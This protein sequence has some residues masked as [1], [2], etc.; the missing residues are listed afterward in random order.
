MSLHLVI[1][2]CGLAGLSAGIS[3]KLANPKHSVTIL[4]TVNDL[5]EVGV[6][7]PLLA[8][9]Q[10][11]PNS[12]RLFKR[13]GIYDRLTPHATSPHT[14]SVRRWDGTKLLATEPRY[15]E[16]IL[17]RY[18]S[19]FWDM[20]R[21]DLQRVMASRAQ[22][23]GVS[24][25]LSSRV[26][27]VDFDAPAAILEG[28]ERIQGDIVLC[29]DG[30]WSG[31]RSKFLGKDSPPAVTGDLAYRILIKASELEDPELRAWVE[32]QTVNLWAGPG[33]HVVGYTVRGKELYNLVFTYPDDLPPGVAKMEGDLEEMRAL[34]RGWD[35]ILRRFLQHV[36]KVEKWK[37][38]W[39]EELPEWKNAQG[40]FV[41]AGDACH[42][43][44]PYLAQGA[45]SSLEDGAVLG[46]LLGKASERRQLKA[47]CDMYQELRKQRG[48]SITKET[49]KQRD[50]FH[51]PDGAEQEERDKLMV[52]QLGAEILAPFPSR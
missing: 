29:A 30:L 27:D 34:F 20:H 4:E 2:G 5:R 42:P 7:I 3:T 15:Q 9:F 6:S 37:L 24:T 11:T 17:S 23:L 14:L 40:T 44:L 22:E 51:M 12:T 43:M 10:L 50:A 52:S 31:T 41:M 46:C 45:N 32:G 1:I 36:K 28:G 47:V 26:V 38:M 21:V 49:F 13:W 33:S 8:G 16:I 18:S 39:L 48:E 25:R 35:P 19:P